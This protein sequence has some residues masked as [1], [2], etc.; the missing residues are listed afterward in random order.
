MRKIFCFLSQLVEWI[1]FL[2]YTRNIL[3]KKSD[4]LFLHRLLN[5]IA[6]SAILIFVPLLIYKSTLNLNT[7][8]LYILLN[9]LFVSILFVVLKKFVQKYG[10]LSLILHIIPIIIAE[11]ILIGNLTTALIIV[12]AFLNA[13]AT[14]LYYGAINT[15]FATLDKT[16]NVA[17]YEAGEICGKI[18][19]TLASSYLIGSLANSIYF[20][21]IFSSILYFVSIIPICFNYKQL[22][23]NY[24]SRKEYTPL[25]VTKYN[26]SY[27]IYNCFMGVI[28]LLIGTILPLY[29][30]YSGFSFT[31]VGI[32][33]ALNL[34][35][36]ILGNYLSVYLEKKNLSKFNVICN[37]I[38]IM[39]STIL[40]IFIKNKYILYG[41]TIVIN[42]SFQMIHIIM[43][44]KYLNES[45]S[46]G[47]YYEAIIQR[48]EYLSLSRATYSAIFLIVPTFFV[49]FIIAILCGAG[50]GTSAVHCLNR[51]FFQNEK[52]L[53]VEQSTAANKNKEKTN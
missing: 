42:F 16:N 35:I 28:V 39:I 46:K 14:V 18:V 44:T 15:I 21:V 30:Y 1:A 50:V 53:T 31:A 34:V 29:L 25:E 5:S 41:L 32:V 7:T 4:I 26:A 11:F 36:R 49:I 2:L 38:I 33:M 17:K 8:I 45:K 9:Y 13:L 43:F 27:N 47:I 24:E 52:Q 40:V 10:L 12:V 6:D 20:I 22:K 23:Q 51:P 48:D 3:M 37:S 19:F